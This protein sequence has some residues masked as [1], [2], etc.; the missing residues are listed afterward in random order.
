RNRIPGI[1]TKIEVDAVVGTVEI[2]YGRHRI[3]SVLTR[4]SIEELG[5]VEGA[6]ATAIIKSTD[7]MMEVSQP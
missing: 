5:L 3:T 4:A 6:L 7:V 1:V 2:R